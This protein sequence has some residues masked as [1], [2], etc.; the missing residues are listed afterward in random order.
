[1]RIPQF[2]F[3]PTLPKKKNNWKMMLEKVTLHGY[4]KLQVSNFQ[5]F[6]Q[7]IHETLTL[8]RTAWEPENFWIA[9]WAET[10]QLPD[11]S[12]GS[13]DGSQSRSPSMLGCASARRFRFRLASS[14]GGV[15][16]KIL[17]MWHIPP[18]KL[19]CPLKRLYFKK[20]FHIPTINFQGTC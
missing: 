16:Y 12:A 13:I 15:I 10:V 4:V 11:S 7:Q 20:K 2:Y 3:P 17:Y 19:T 8:K 1:M 5:F 9:R 18:K 14:W 6:L